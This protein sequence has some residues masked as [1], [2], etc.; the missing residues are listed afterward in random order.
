MNFF[1]KL[2]CRTFQTCLKIALPFL[3]YREPRILKTNSEVCEVLKSN[4]ID[5]VLFVTD[6]GIRGLGLTKKLEEEIKKQKIKLVVYED[7][8]PNPTTQNVDEIVS[9][10]PK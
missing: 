10:I 9:S 3:P 7:V 5:S 8:V 1:K 4:N 6:K 2:Y